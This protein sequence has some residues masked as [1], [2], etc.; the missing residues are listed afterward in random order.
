MASKTQIVNRAFVK[1]G[2]RPATNV[3][4]DDS[5]DTRTALNIYDIALET[6]LTETLWTFAKDYALL[7][8][9]TDTVPF[10]LSD[11]SLNIRYQRPQGALRIFDI[12]DDT[13]DWYEIGDQIWADTAGLGAVFTYLNTDPATYK[14]YFITAFSDLLAAEMAYPLLNSKSKT[15]DLFDFYER[16]SLPKA[17]A[18]NAQ[19]GKARSPKDD[20][21]ENA[22]FGGPNVVGGD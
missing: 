14:P 5:E 9:T 4:T 3:D 11:E 6:I 21:W 13:A 7:A 10:N 17:K 20:Y 8:T 16:I 22:R 15:D 2:V 18:I 1:L 12:S 19:T